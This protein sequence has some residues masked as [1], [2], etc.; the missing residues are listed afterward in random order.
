[1][2]D[3]N[4]VEIEDLGD[5]ELKAVFERIKEDFFY[6]LAEED[7]LVEVLVEEALKRKKITVSENDFYALAEEFIECFH[8]MAHW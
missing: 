2:C 3:E 5:E 8:G 1:M 7:D 6:N 4:E